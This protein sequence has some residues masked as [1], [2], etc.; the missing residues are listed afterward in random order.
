MASNRNHDPET[1]PAHASPKWLIYAV[2][3]I[4][5]ALV[6][7]DFLYEKHG[8]LA[9]ED[10]PLFYALLGFF[11]SLVLLVCAKI[12]RLIVGRREDYYAPRDVIAEPYTEAQLD[13]V[14]DNA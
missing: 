4:C 6:A 3:A 10:V 13:K 5:V 7:V 12:L 14:D 9:I 1:R 8:Y 11:A 2:F